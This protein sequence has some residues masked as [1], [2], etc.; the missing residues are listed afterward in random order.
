MA[1]Q[2]S[3]RLALP[4]IL[5]TVATLPAQAGGDDVPP[6]AIPA[7]CG[8]CHALDEP[9]LGPSYRAIATKY[10]DDDDAATT[11]VASMREGSSGTWGQVPMMPVPAAQLSDE[12][13]AAVVSWI[14][15]L[16]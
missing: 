5:V 15:E 8:G 10:A 2:L 13:L 9:M 7:S 14:L 4:L 16:N 6:E 12:D 3:W 11:L 1:K